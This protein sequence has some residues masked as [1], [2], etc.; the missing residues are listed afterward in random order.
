VELADKLL[1]NLTPIDSSVDKAW[2]QESERRLKEYRDGKV[3]AIPG[4]QVFKNIY[5]RFG[6]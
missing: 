1:L 5:K 6:K 3:E 2:L 4:D